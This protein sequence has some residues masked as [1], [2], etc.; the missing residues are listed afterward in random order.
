MVD[1]RPKVNDNI[2][3][4]FISFIFVISYVHMLI[5]IDYKRLCPAHL[6][7]LILRERKILSKEAKKCAKILFKDCVPFY[8]EI[9]NHQDNGNPVIGYNH[10]LKQQ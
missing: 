7:S 3:I 1:D 9:R 2:L 6:V 8:K 10:N 4:S 5:I